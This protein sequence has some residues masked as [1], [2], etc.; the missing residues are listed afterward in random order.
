MKLCKNTFEWINCSFSLNREGEKKNSQDKKVTDRSDIDKKN[1][2]NFE[3]FGASSKID[4]Q[5]SELIKPA[6]KKQLVEEIEKTYFPFS[7]ET[8]QKKIAAILQFLINQQQVNGEFKSLC[9]LTQQ[10]QLGWFY[11]G[12]SPFLTSNILFSLLELKTKEAKQII[13][14]GTDFL[15]SQKNSIGLWRYWNHNNG[16]ME[17][18]VPCD[19]DDTC[20]VSFILEKESITALNNKKYI[21]ANRNEKGQFNTWFVPQLKLIKFPL[22]YYWLKQDFKYA[23]GVFFPEHEPL[24]DLEDNE[25]AV[26]AHALLYLGENKQTQ[27]AIEAIIEN[28]KDQ[29]CRLEYY[30]NLAVVY[31][32]LSRA[33]K[34]GVKGFA[35]IKHKIQKDL[36]EINYQKL[37]VD[38]YL[39]KVF[40]VL[41]LQNFNLTQSVIYEQLMHELIEDE[42]HKNGWKTYKYWT[43]KQR[44]FLAGSQELTAA[45]YLEAL[46]K[47]IDYDTEK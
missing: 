2:D 33:Y 47:H 20:L 31:Y 32:H 10:P 4:T 6:P 27:K 36:E 3:I 11:S 29:N 5:L 12:A 38:N 44:G 42:M 16:I 24:C 45:L 22:Y 35:L 34:Y 21:Y 14:K 13:K 17:H 40:A 9:F 30:D 39:Q 37:G 23:K 43:T 46:Q 25:P 26:A 18:N 8:I 15:I 7:K 1:H 19:L 41:T 28:V